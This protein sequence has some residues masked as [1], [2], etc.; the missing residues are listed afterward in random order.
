M[1]NAALW[2][3]ARVGL[4]ARVL[5]NNKITVRYATTSLMCVSS[6]TKRTR[7][8]GKNRGWAWQPISS[9]TQQAFASGAGDQGSA[10]PALKS[11]RAELCRLAN[12]DVET[13]S[14][15]RT[16]LAIDPDMNGALVVFRYRRRRPHD[17]A[18]DT[19]SSEPVDVVRLHELDQ[20][21]AQ[22][23]ICSTHV[24]LLPHSL[25]ETAC[26]RGVLHRI[27]AQHC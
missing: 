15:E 7:A 16:V 13:A 23:S 21:L 18:T 9:Q 24:V 17:A 26:M 25:S 6:N 3:L 11:P 10:W 5:S 20:R 27:G 14:Q 8:S 19:R 1:Y 22:V 12:L 2:Q 4:P